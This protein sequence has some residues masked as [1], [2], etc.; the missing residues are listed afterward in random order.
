MNRSIN[1]PLDLGAECQTTEWWLL[2]SVHLLRFGA[3]GRRST[4]W[5]L[6]A[7]WLCFHV[8]IGSPM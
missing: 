6:H 3:P 4:D 7:G 8:W 2:P 1:I 5:T